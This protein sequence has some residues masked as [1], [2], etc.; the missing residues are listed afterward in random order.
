[1]LTVRVR[2]LGAPDEL[3]GPAL[4]GGVVS[5]GTPEQVAVTALLAPLLLHELAALRRT[6][7]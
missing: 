2:L 7:G 5:L 4:E 6:G 3:V 1:M